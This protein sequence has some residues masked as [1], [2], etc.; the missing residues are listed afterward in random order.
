MTSATGSLRANITSDANL[1]QGEDRTLRWVVK[2]VDGV[3]VVSFSGWTFAWYLMRALTDDHADALIT[4]TSSSG[5]A[6]SAPDVDVSIDPVDTADLNSG[7]YVYELWR[8]DTNNV[9]RLA[10]GTV[11]IID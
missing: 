6:T 10:Y 9:I 3:D 5:I 1:T 2:D 4:K 8:T 11:P 7:G